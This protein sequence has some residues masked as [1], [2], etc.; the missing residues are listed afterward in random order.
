M[1]PHWRLIRCYLRACLGVVVHTWKSVVSGEY[2]WL[3]RK[4]VEGKGG[5]CGMPLWALVLENLFGHGGQKTSFS[6][7]CI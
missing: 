1:S 6:D 5:G 4:L 7:T 2:A 3:R